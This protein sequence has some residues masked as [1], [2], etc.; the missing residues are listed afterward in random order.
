MKRTRAVALALVNWRGVF[1]E[2]Y[3]LDRHVTALEGANGSGKTTVMIAAYVVLLPDL[4]RLRFTNLGETGATGGDR[5]IWGRLGELGR[6]SYAVLSLELPSGETMLAGVQLER[7][8]EPALE[9]T[10]FLVEGVAESGRL[11][12]ILLCTTGDQ[13]EIPTLPQLR[14]N[15]KQAGARLTV[16]PSAKEYFAALFDRGVTPMRLT[17]DEQRNKFNEMLRTSM[18]GGISRALTS[19]LRS[20]VLREESALSETLSRMRGNLDACRKTRNEVKEARV[21]E[22]EIGGIFEAG[23]AMARAALEAVRC[24]VREHNAAVAALRGSYDVKARD[25]AKLERDLAALEARKSAVTGQ[26]EVAGKQL[27]AAKADRDRLTR[28]VALRE[29]VDALGGELERLGIELEASAAA[30]RQVTEQRTRSR[31]LWS[32]RQTELVESARSLADVQAGLDALARR[33]H[34]RRLATERLAALR[35]TTGNVALGLAELPGL[36][37]QLTVEQRE[38]DR[39]LA[40]FERH[41]ALEETVGRDRETAL[42]ALRRIAGDVSESDDLYARAK[43]ELRR[44]RQLQA[45]A[46]RLGARTRE[47]EQAREQLERREALIRKLDALGL[48][49]APADATAFLE[50]LWTADRDAAMTEELQREEDWRAREAAVS[51]EQL[52]A[53]IAVLE[54]REGEWAQVQRALDELGDLVSGLEPGRVA[55]QRL[56]EQWLARQTRAHAELERCTRERAEALAHA[57]ALDSS[58]SVSPGL[59][60]LELKELL[61]AE[62]LAQRYDDLEDDEA[63]R[64]EAILGPL[65]DALVVEDLDAAATVLQ[66]RPIA[67]ETA[68]IVGA[69][70][71]PMRSLGA[72]T[73]VDPAGTVMV[74]TSM[75]LRI[76]RIPEK[77]RLGRQARARQSAERRAHAQECATAIETLEGE[78]RQITGVLHAIDALDFLIPAWQAGDPGRALVALRQRAT[79]T[80]EAQA[81]ARARSN[82]AGARLPELRRLANALRALLPQAGDLHAPL[83]AEA[84]T[85]LQAAQRESEASRVE[86]DRIG[87]SASVLAELVEALC[88]PLQSPEQR[89]ERAQERVALERRRDELYTQLESIDALELHGNLLEEAEAFTENADPGALV[90]ELRTHHQ[91][92]ELALE[93]AKQRMDAS[94]SEWQALTDAHHRNVATVEAAKAHHQRALVELQS[95]GFVEPTAEA[96]QELDQTIDRQFLSIAAHTREERD[97][98]TRIALERDRGSRLTAELSALQSDQESAEDAAKPAALAWT[99]L[100]QRA[101]SAGLTAATPGDLVEQKSSAWWPEARSRSAL[102]LDR[103]QTARGGSEL[104]RDLH[105]RLHHED[106]DSFFDAWLATRAWLQRRLPAHITEGE[107]PL[108]GLSRLRDDLVRL[109]GR[110]GRQEDDLR[111]T[112]QD[113]ARSI[114]VQIRRAVN[115]VERLNRS[116]VDVTF[117]SIEG[118]RIKLQRLENMEP[119]WG[120]L[121]DGSAQQLLFHS[122]MSI[123]DAMEEIFRRYGGGGKA[124]AQKILDYREYIELR[125]EVRRRGDGKDWEL[126]NPTRVSTGEAIGVGAALMMVILTEWERDANLLRA[127]RGAGCLRFL[128]LDEANRLSQDNLAVLFDLCE[129]LDLQL[130]IA[131]PEVAHAEGNTTYR[132]IRRQLEDGREEVVVSGRRSTL[133]EAMNVALPVAL[134]E[135]GPVSD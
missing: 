27:E 96:L 95:A 47:A 73:S 67:V 81:T 86:L 78:Q 44:I 105:A 56:R 66:K 42:S 130:L 4:T 50:R 101:A 113:V 52:A 57:Q 59:D 85:E 48:H 120:A 89:L 64:T 7:K 19:Q 129:R 94:E 75:G 74:E 134:E 132:L 112:S 5:G 124:G 109:E 8:G 92:A 29:R 84:V 22:H 11:Q 1:Y 119:V 28:A 21:L 111:G 107:E 106:G 40:R 25:Q 91:R 127:Q 63:R 13:E 65:V 115:Q 69:G 24:S 123:E 72:G 15:A 90:T 9:L 62:F 55:T 93:D 30:Y 14:A 60:L 100:Q 97:L 17:L 118:I 10:P 79:A 53:E 103:L 110:L 77:A 128:F 2:R 99:Q 12:D 51:G 133:P 37:E 121:R 41:D 43:Q 88:E 20:F 31:E 71:D 36:R 131:A 80:S 70:T 23:Q 45:V 117:G 38:V 87:D 18:T 76:G 108:L 102:L 34:A 68:W 6:P 135:V 82:A 58:E 39:A 122:S 26:L 126:A 33:M 46:D 49:P 83:S 16:F 3:L 114:D 98:E 35:Q 32:Q 54:R 116:L 125:V 104:A 61:D